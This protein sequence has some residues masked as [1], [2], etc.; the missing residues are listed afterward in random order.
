VRTPIRLDPN[1][2]PKVGVK[3]YPKESLRA[4][5]QGDC[6]VR[7]TVTADGLVKDPEIVK[8]TGYARLDEACLEAFKDGQ[9]FPA[10]QDGKPVEVK[11]TIPITWK[12]TH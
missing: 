3:Y 7:I 9:F 10:T 2:L 4:H 8:S 5:E 6:Q 11:A 12:L 1:H